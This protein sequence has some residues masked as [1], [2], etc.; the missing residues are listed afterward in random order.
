VYGIRGK[1]ISV[2]EIPLD[3]NVAEILTQ[4]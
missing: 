3:L 1:N 4:I 2:A